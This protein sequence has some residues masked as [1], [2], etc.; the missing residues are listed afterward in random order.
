MILD[1][2][3]KDVR[4]QVVGTAA[5]ALLWASAY[6]DEW[7]NGSPPAFGPLGE[8]DGSVAVGQAVVVAPPTGAYQR[9]VKYLT[10]NNPNV[11]AISV[12]I[13]LNNRVTF[14]ASIP[15]GG[16]LTYVW[17]VGWQVFYADGT[18]VTAGASGG[19]PNLSQVLTA[20]NTGGG[21]S[22]F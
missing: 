8:A 7:P 21:F 6:A 20:G 22:I 11:R 19:I 1:S 3:A 10:V 2:A 12:Q 17:A 5:V 9:Q 16:T 18:L 14:A 4:L 13:L 15:A